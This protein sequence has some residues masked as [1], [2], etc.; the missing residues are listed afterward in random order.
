[1]KLSVLMF[2]FWRQRNRDWLSVDFATNS[3]N[4]MDPVPD[5]WKVDYSPRSMFTGFYRRI[6]GLV[7]NEANCSRN[8]WRPTICFP[9]SI[10]DPNIWPSLFGSESNQAA[11]LGQFCSRRCEFS[12]RPERR[13]HL[14]VCDHYKWDVYC[15]FWLAGGSAGNSLIIVN[16]IKMKCARAVHFDFAMRFEIG[17][18]GKRMQ[19]IAQFLAIL[20]EP[21]QM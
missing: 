17:D 18:L 14:D 16:E 2:S 13:V 12:V 10:A 21:I 1:M 8:F 19:T 11:D 4:E 6:P 3:L 5:N 7:W 15:L 20:V 9:M